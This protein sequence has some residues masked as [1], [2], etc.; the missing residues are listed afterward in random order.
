MKKLNQSKGFTLIE[1]MI[2]IAIVAILA[3]V[4][5]PTYRNYTI[6]AKVSEGLAAAAE[7]KV[8]VMEYYS[9]HL[10][11]PPGGDNEAAGFEQ[12]YYSDYV[13]TVDWH[14]DQRIEIEFNEANLGISKQL[15]VQLDPEID[16]RGRLTWRCGQDENVPEENY[17]FLPAD[18]RER[19][20]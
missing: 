2:V 20:W 5:L 10:E 8:A 14:D 18:C 19:Y 15:E 7:A 17:K 16:A 6:R 1:L 3:A 13:D 11:L 9:V 4:A 12:D